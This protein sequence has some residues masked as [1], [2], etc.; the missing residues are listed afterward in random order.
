[1]QREASGYHKTGIGEEH[2]LPSAKNILAEHEHKRDAILRG[3]WRESREG[4]WNSWS[5]RSS[6]TEKEAMDTAISG[7]LQA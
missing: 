3:Y 5:L 4:Y 7:R 2:Y 1:M 6:G